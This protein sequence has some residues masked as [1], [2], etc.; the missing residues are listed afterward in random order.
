MLDSGEETTQTHASPAPMR[1]VAKR[2]MQQSAR[3]A[4]AG[5]AAASAA[6]NNAPAAMGITKPRSA[7]GRAFDH[8]PGTETLKVFARLV[9]SVSPCDPLLQCRGLHHK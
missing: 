2:E 8:P 6:L 3:A 1:L 5:R 7:Q 4:R 9:F